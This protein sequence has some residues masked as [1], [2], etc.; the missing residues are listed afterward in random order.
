[1][2]ATL[3]ARDYKLV[4]G[5][6]DTALILLDLRP[7]GLTGKAAV[8]SLE[9]AGLTCNKNAIPGDPQPPTVTSGV[10]LSAAVG[11]TRGFSQDEFQRIGHWIAA[12]LDGLREHP[13][14]NHATERAVRAQVA[15]LC[16][17][18]PIYS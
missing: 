5:G 10:R 6:T 1:M 2:A 9:G 18:F 8:A 17:R 11:T 16:Q 7:Q 12:V 4:S 14:N 3:Q 15:E 13:Q